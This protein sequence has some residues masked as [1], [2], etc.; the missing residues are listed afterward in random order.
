V[1]A[2]ASCREPTQVLIEARTNLAYRA[3]LVTSFTVGG[4]GE[5]EGA[6][7]TTESRDP[8]GAD[9][10]VGSLTVVPSS[11]DD[12]RLSVRLVLGVDRDARS[13][14]PPDFKGCIIARRSLRYTP[15]ERLR[16][17]IALYAQCKD[18]PCDAAST[19]N[20]LG[21][22]VAAEVDA[23]TCETDRGCL[24]PGDPSSGDLGPGDGGGPVLMDGAIIDGPVA[25]DT[26]GDTSS[27]GDAGDGSVDAPNDAPNDAAG[28]LGKIECAGV[29][30][31]KAA[32]QVCCFDPVL[33]TGRCA[34]AALGCGSAQNPEYTVQCDGAEDCGLNSSC[35]VTTNNFFCYAGPT[36]MG[37]PRVCHSTNTCPTGGCTGTMGGHYKVCQ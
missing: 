34:T 37:F 23:A 33:Q 4:P 10:F 35:C 15:H 36:C 26:G 1:P 6:G 32:G 5:T 7:P 27:P 31:D 11:A 13:C 24:V 30:C 8:W 28:S 22:C 19:C 16:L 3:G 9:G 20:V 21:Q 2:I 12:A 25:A 29:T 17:P 18:V 14:T